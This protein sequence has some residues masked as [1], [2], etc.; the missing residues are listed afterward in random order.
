MKTPAAELAGRAGSSPRGPTLQR[1]RTFCGRFTEHP[2]VKLPGRHCGRSIEPED[3]ARVCK[4][5]SSCRVSSWM[6]RRVG[7]GSVVLGVLTLL[8]VVVGPDVA[9]VAIQRSALTNRCSMHDADNSSIGLDCDVWTMRG[10]KATLHE[11][12]DVCPGGRITE[13]WLAAIRPHDYAAHRS[14]SIATDVHPNSDSTKSDRQ[15]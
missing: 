4:E 12:D 14:A 10:I 3:G 2:T 5:V 11:L 9:Q 7:R 15:L 1:M 13:N 6:R 8:H